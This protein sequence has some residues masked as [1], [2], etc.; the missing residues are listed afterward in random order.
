MLR[1]ARNL[2]EFMGDM[3]LSTLSEEVNIPQPTLS[4]YLQCKRQIT[5]ENL[6]KLADYFDVDIDILIGRKDY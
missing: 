4:R 6:I 5:L 1:L 2:K 3:S